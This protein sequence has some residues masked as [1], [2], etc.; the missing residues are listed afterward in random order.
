LRRGH[1]I[2]EWGT[3]RD[4][5]LFQLLPEAQVLRVPLLQ[6]FEPSLIRGK[7]VWLHIN[8][9]RLT[10][11]QLL[12][13][14]F[15]ASLKRRPRA[16]RNAW[17]LDTCK[18]EL[19]ARLAAAGLNSVAA[20]QAG[21]A[22]EALIVKT[23][24]NYGAFMERQ[25]GARTRKRLMIEEPPADIVDAAAYRVLPRAYVPERYWRDPAV[26]IERYVR[27]RQGRF[28]RAY[29]CGR[30]WVISFGKARGHVLKMMPGIER[31][32]HFWAEGSSWPAALGDGLREQLVGAANVMKLDFGA[33]D[34]VLDER[35]RAF[36]ID[37]NPTPFWG[38]EAQEGLVEHLREGSK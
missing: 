3:G 36:V 7:I 1:T 25:L 6:A 30:Q 33:I 12:Q 34:A 5:L 16:M 13:G 14:A 11:L 28:V 31:S 35:S 10:H 38:D 32:N 29:R 17:C 20:P 4:Y 24:A 19:Q 22:D 9:S 23:N 15:A 21:R 18:R 27:N 26:V 2:L 8:L 37:V